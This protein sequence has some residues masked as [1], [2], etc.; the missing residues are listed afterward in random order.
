MSTPQFAPITNW[1]TSTPALG[2]L[3]QEEF[4]KLYGTMYQYWEDCAKAAIGQVL[5]TTAQELQGNMADD[6]VL[7]QAQL[8][9]VID[10][11][12]LAAA[13]AKKDSSGY[14]YDEQVYTDQF[15]SSH[16]LTFSA[17]AVPAGQFRLPWLQGMSPV[18]AN[19]GSGSGANQ[20][21][22]QNWQPGVYGDSARHLYGHFFASSNGRA[23][24]TGL[25][26]GVFSLSPGGQP[27]NL[28][29][30]RGDGGQPRYYFDS[31]NVSPVRDHANPPCTII[32]GF[33][34]VQYTVQGVG[35]FK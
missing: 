20:G 16:D 30:D 21:F 4:N 31:S 2:T 5:F 19:L 17:S 7:G 10:Y 11:P 22:Y 33:V 35:V 29:G 23:D 14:I 15:D 1:T 34:R 3:W 8:L 28:A 32:F 25:T 18:I 24:S 13:Y 6:F 26:G 12:I 27:G 9:N